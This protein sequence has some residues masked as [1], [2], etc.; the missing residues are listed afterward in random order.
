MYKE[1]R[2]MNAKKKG[3]KKKYGGMKVL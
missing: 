3:K 2:P 1:N